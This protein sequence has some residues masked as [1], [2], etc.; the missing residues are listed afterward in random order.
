MQ[1]TDLSSNELAKVYTRICVLVENTFLTSPGF[2][3][4]GLP[5]N[6]HGISFS[7]ANSLLAVEHL[8]RDSPPLGLSNVV[9]LRASQHIY[10]SRRYT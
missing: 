3:N 9:S 5:D 8:A 2:R 7:T 1:V 4:S 6:I 10:Q